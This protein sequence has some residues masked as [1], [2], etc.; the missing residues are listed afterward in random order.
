[1]TRVIGINFRENGKI[2]FFNPADYS[3]KIGDKVIVETKLGKELGTVK[4]SLREI[5]E[6]KLKEPVKKVLRM[7]SKEDEM[8]QLE[9]IKKKKKLK[10]YLIKR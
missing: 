5:D 6:S 8:H 1:M 2:Y 9:N 7:A 4:T 3:L 10:L